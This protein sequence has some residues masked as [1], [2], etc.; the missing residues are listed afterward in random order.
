MA[1]RD[2][3]NQFFYSYYLTLL[4]DTFYV[5]T[6]ADH[7]SGK[8]CLGM[9][10]GYISYLAGFKLQSMMLARMFNLVE[11]GQIGASLAESAQAD[12]SITNSVFL[13]QFCKDLLTRAF[14]NLLPSVYHICLV[15]C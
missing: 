14:S 15:K 6:D 8:I 4:Q 10:L 3:A 1:D 7:K 13:K 12:P 11:S 2:I 5:L 9:S